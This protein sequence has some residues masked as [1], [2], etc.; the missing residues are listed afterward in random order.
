MADDPLIGFSVDGFRFDSLLGRG[1]MGAVYKGVQIALDRQVAIKVIAPHLAEDDSYISRFHREAQTL[2]RLVHPHVIAC[3]DTARCKGPHGN[4]IVLMVLEFVD[5]WSL[6]TLL[7]KKYRMTAKQMVEIHRQAAEG[8][9]AAHR[10]GIIHRDIKPD[11]IMIT[12]KGQAKLADFGLAKADDSAMLTQTGAIMGSPAYMSP[13]AC[14][15][16]LPI[17][18][19]DLYSLG[20]SLYHGLTGTTPY[21]ASS[22]I[23]ALHQ[24]VHAPIPRLSERRPDLVEL[25]ELLAKMLAKRANDR[26]TDAATLSAALKAAIAVIPDDAPAGVSTAT[27]KEDATQVD[28]HHATATIHPNTAATKRRWPWI[29]A[30]I[31]GVFFFIILAV[32]LSRHKTPKTMTID[33]TVVATLDS[34]ET[35]INQGQLSAAD[36]LFKRLTHDQLT[37]N[38]A[39]IPRIETIQQRLSKPT[40]TIQKNVPATSPLTQLNKAEDLFAAGKIEEADAALSTVQPNADIAARSDGLK[41][42]LGKEYQSRFERTEL[43]IAAAEMQ[44][45]QGQKQ[46]A[47]KSLESI[48]PPRIFPNL[49]KRYNTVMKATATT[50]STVNNVFV[51]KPGDAGFVEQVLPVGYFSLPFGI[52]ANVDHLIMSRDSRITIK[53]SA[54][55]SA[56]TDGC[57]LLLHVSLSCD[58]H[59]T[60]VCG[61]ERF[62]R[63]SQRVTAM[64]WE[65]FIIALDA[66]KAVTAVEIVAVNTESEVRPVMHVARAVVTKGRS[67]TVADLSLVPGGLQPLPLVVGTRPEGDQDYRFVVAQILRNLSSFAKLDSVAVAQPKNNSGTGEQLIMIANKLLGVSSKENLPAVFSYDDADS[68]KSAFSQSIGKVDILFIIVDTAKMPTK[69]TANAVADH[70]RTAIDGGTLPV[71]IM[72]QHKSE[73]A[74]LFGKWQMYLNRVHALTPVVP[75]INLSLASQFAKRTRLAQN[76]SDSANKLIADCLLGGLQEL[77]ARLNVVI[78]LSGE[79]RSGDD[80]KR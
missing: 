43:V 80:L 26:F 5:G 64:Q 68:L 50:G 47:R 62:E 66:T 22:A 75:V 13:E 76:D 34:V 21:R 33:N 73:Q 6:G 54:T 48:T 3:H 14:R 17:P 9:S 30:G 40:E 74:E 42:K 31:A 45:S 35:L 1:A 72:S 32:S 41:Q 51:I 63:P 52:P 37:S 23:Q 12:R 15:G 36:V 28:A 7:K 8:L 69:E 27:P 79:R 61:S 53:P 65:P 24:H 39:L 16:E 2:G 18:A 25:D 67:A 11:N 71:L 59:T 29:A 56:G 10:L 55:T 19:S 44:L 77:F 46:E 38:S 20:C 4:E 49:I 78:N 58:V 70:C 60:L 57:A